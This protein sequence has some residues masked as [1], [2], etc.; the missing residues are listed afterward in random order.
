MCIHRSR[1]EKNTMAVSII[2]HKQATALAALDAPA[3]LASRPR[4]R[5]ARGT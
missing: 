1:I 4:L 3:A 2:I 5:N